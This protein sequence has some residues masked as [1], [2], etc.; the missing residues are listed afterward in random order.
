MLEKIF[1]KLLYTLFFAIL[2]FEVCSCSKHAE[3]VKFY[4]TGGSQNEQDWKEIE[5]TDYTFASPEHIV[6]ENEIFRVTY[7]TLRKD[8]Q[9]G[10]S[11][12][13][14][15][16]KAWMRV[17]SEDY[18]DYTYFIDSIRT[19]PEKID[20][21]KN[22][23]DEVTLA[24]SYHHKNYRADS[25]LKWAYKG[26]IV[27]KK[28]MTLKKGL[29]GVFVKLYSEPRNPH[30]EREIGFGAE[31]SLVYSERVMAL[32][33]V[34]RRHIDLQMTQAKDLYA[35]SLPLSN[36]F[37][38]ILILARPM[39]T[40]SYQF[41]PQAGGGRLIVN[42]LIEDEQDAYQVFLGA[43]PYDSTDAL[44]EVEST[45][46]T[47]V[48]SRIDDPAASSGHFIRIGDGNVV[49]LTI[50]FI[51]KISGTYRLG[52]RCRSV[53]ETAKMSVRLDSKKLGEFQI[54][55][56]HFEQYMLTDRQIIS[57][58]EHH[59]TVL[60]HEGRID[61]DALAILPLTSSKNFPLNIVETVT[62]QFRSLSSGFPAS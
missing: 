20:I 56:E 1:M 14:K 8:Q 52:L 59:V 47:P 30:G 25:S 31:S 57:R 40:F 34:A 23:P 9:A 5:G 16:K 53:G 45:L 35:V 24:F 28:V 6:F 49:E 21:L 26:D 50:P 33:P 4:D 36:S 37:Y 46:A 48:P 41:K 29:P 60:I 3:D 32:H 44:T 43:V 55:H 10:H 17:T 58:G 27:L 42:Q 38:R 7:P 51:V 15:V 62:P 18:G 2:L 11:Y 39:L 22:T 61:L 13:V 19:S 54:E 12:F